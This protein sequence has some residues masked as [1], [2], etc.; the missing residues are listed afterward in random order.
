MK[1]NSKIKANRSDKSIAL[2]KQTRTKK[3][4]DIKRTATP[5]LK[6]NQSSM[7]AIGTR[8]GTGAR[9]GAGTGAGMTKATST[10]VV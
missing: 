4:L 9:T 10:L 6:P 1:N 3:A 5:L 2:L 8:A 7:I